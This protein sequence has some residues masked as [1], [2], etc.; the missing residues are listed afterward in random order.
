MK[1]AVS[2]ENGPDAKLTDSLICLGL[3]D[4]LDDETAKDMLH[5]FWQ[6]LNDGGL[7]MLGNFASNNPTRAYME[8]IGN[9]YLNYRTVEELQQLGI[10][11]GIPEDQFFVGS[12]PLGVNL[13]LT[14][15]K[16]A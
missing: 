6:Q 10:Q 8:W 11:A 1:L 15:Q 4:Y 5:L 16:R 2:L 9:W 7:L 14:G 12:E 13:I 3:F